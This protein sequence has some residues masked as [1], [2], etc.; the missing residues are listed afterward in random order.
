VVLHL[1][2]FLA[3]VV[4]TMIVHLDDLK[5]I[6]MVQKGAPTRMPFLY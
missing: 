2:A 4:L 5:Q 3:G 6:L 1:V